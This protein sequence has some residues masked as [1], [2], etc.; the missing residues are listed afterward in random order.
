MIKK[1]E[2][3]SKRGKLFNLSLTITTLEKMMEEHKENPIDQ[4]LQ[5]EICRLEKE[6]KKIIKNGKGR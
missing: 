4:F 1:T 3:L 6:K 2:E 5:K